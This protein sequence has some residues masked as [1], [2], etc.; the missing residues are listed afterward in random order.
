MAIPCP[1]NPCQF[2]IVIFNKKNDNQQMKQVWMLTLMFMG[3]QGMAQKNE[4]NTAVFQKDGFAIRGY[5][6]VAYFTL[7][8]PKKGDE[9]I[10]FS[11]QGAMWLFS[12]EQHKT[13]FVQ[14]PEKYAPQYGG[15]CAWG[16]SENYK[17]TTDPFAWTITNGKLYLNYNRKVQ[18]AWA[19]QKITRIPKADSNWTTLAGM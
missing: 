4:A 14:Q 13:L 15:Y 5:D 9:K 19:P 16:A 18:A 10:S 2:C 8:E 17:A 7:G 1:L 12:S 3:F 11:W 6:P